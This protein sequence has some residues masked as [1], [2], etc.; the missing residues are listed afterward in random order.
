MAKRARK[1][2]TRKQFLAAYKLILQKNMLWAQDEHKLNL[3]M[4]V[5]EDTLKGND[6]VTK[7]VWDGSL[8]RRA[9]R[10]IGCVGVPTLPKLKALTNE[11]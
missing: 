4:G 11:G 5:V 6:A 9:W 3:F 2:P 7:W 10:E 8:T 1:Q